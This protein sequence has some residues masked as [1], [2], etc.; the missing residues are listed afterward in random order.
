MWE[1]NRMLGWELGSS[2]LRACC[3]GRAL[4]EPLPGE[5]NKALVWFSVFHAQ[6]VILFLRIWEI[7][8][9]CSLG[10]FYWFIVRNFISSGRNNY[11]CYSEH[12]LCNIRAPGKLNWQSECFLMNMM[13]EPKEWNRLWGV[14]FISG[15]AWTLAF[16]SLLY[17]FFLW[18]KK[19]RFLL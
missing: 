18:K 3:V 11:P 17:H 4:Q 9:N 15:T 16:A 12:Y 7:D 1:G 5:L 13:L 2:E 19:K 6:E 10:P 14:S 8:W